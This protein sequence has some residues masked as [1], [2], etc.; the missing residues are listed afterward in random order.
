MNL[1]MRPSSGLV[2][3]S[4]LS[5][6]DAASRDLFAPCPGKSR[7]KNACNSVGGGQPDTGVQTD[8]PMDAEIAV[9]E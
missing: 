4:R 7:A 2:T 5:A 6:S 3:I 9:N 8:S 1:S